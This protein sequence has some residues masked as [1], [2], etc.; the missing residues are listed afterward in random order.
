MFGAGYANAADRLFLMESCATPA[1]PS[2]HPSSAARRRTAR[3]TLAVEFAPYTEAELAGAGRPVPEMYGADGAEGGNRRRRLR[4][5]AS[6]PTSR[7]RKAILRCSPASHAA[8]Q[9]D[10]TLEGDRR[11]RDRLAGRRDLRQGRRHEVD[12]AETM[13]AFVGRIGHGGRGQR[14]ARLPRQERPGGA[15]ER[16]RRSSPMGPRSAFAA[17]RPGAAGC[18]IRGGPSRR[19]PRR[20][21][22][23]ARAAPGKP[24]CF[25]C[26]EP[27]VQGPGHASNWELVK[28]KKSRHG[29]PDRRV[30]PAGRLLR[31]ADP[32]GEGHAGP[33]IDARGASFAGV[34]LYVQLGHGR[35]Y[36]WSATSAELRQRRHV[37]R[38][39]LQ[40]QLPLPLPRQVPGD[41]EARRR[42]RAGRR[43]RST[44]PRRALR[45]WSPTGRCTGS[46][47]P[48]ARSTA[49]RSPTCS[50]RSTYFH[51]ADSVIGFGQLNE[52]EA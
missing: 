6:T 34:D 40:R 51:E 26:R 14:L 42:P 38:G 47:S 37:R 32:H 27:R 31:P 12:S 30:R 48:A 13:Q 29:P 4:R 50:Q 46:S 9:A 5:R 15:D 39:A 41:G 8:R 1:A 20:A 22:A 10:G 35:D 23:S 44:R 3:W 18:R 49:R 21:S 25:G 16:S 19:P 24:R 33:G 52:P 28:A 7:L 2:S 17:R 43:T 36:A 11:D 45:P